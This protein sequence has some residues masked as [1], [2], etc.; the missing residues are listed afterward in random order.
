MTPLAYRAHFGYGGKQ[1]LSRSPR[2]EADTTAISG[3]IRLLLDYIDELGADR[4]AVVFDGPDSWGSRQR[5]IDAV[6]AL[7]RATAA[8]AR[9]TAAQQAEQRAGLERCRK[10]LEEV[11]DDGQYHNQ[12]QLV[13]VAREA[14]AAVAAQAGTPAVGSSSSLHSALMAAAT[15]GAG[16]GGAQELAFLQESAATAAA[17]VAAAPASPTRTLE[18][19]LQRHQEEGEIEEATAREL[20]PAVI[21]GLAQLADAEAAVSA[22]AAWS[23]TLASYPAYRLLSCSG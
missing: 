19:V 2:T 13:V 5:C 18:A 1:V 3:A 6:S 17:A 8:T 20:G 16:D 12:Q 22:T 4:V 14:A 7:G 21:E 10:L 15:A 23:T 9:S 11:A